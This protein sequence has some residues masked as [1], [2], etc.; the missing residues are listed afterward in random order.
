MSRHFPLPYKPPGKEGKTEQE[1]LT[2]AQD[3]L[4]TMYHWEHFS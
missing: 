4:G 2:T 1:G 3:S